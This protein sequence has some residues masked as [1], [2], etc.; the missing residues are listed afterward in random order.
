LLNPVKNA[1]FIL[2]KLILLDDSMFNHQ[3]KKCSPL[4]PK[5]MPTLTLEIIII[6]AAVAA[7]AVVLVVRNMKDEKKLKKE[8]IEEEEVSIKD[9]DDDKE[10]SEA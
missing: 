6:I 9:N 2:L 3:L 1:I 7:I 4:K 10:D 5:A 8:L